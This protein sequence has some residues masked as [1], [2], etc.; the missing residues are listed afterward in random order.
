MKLRW[1]PAKQDPAI[2][3]LLSAYRAQDKA[4]CSYRDCSAIDE[5]VRRAQSVVD[6]I[7]NGIRRET[8]G[9]LHGGVRK[10]AN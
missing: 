10:R 3:R 4:V 6:G 2:K 1:R 5:E 7:A 8:W 9:Y